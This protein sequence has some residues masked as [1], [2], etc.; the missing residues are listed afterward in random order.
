MIERI[1]TPVRR[2]LGPFANP[3]LRAAQSLRR[4]LA[5]AWLLVVWGGERRRRAL[6]WLL[7]RHYRALFLRQW[8]WADEEP[9]FF[10]HRI[11]SFEFAI[12]DHHGFTHYRG[13]FAA[14][15]VREGDRVLD[16]GCGDGFFTRRFLAPV[17]ARVDG[18]DIEP[19]AIEH[20]KAHNAAS[21]V[22]YFTSDAVA[23][24]FPAAEYDL[25]VWD[26]ALGHFPP[27]TT[28]RMLAKIRAALSD[29]GA[30]VGSESLGRVEGQ[31]DHLQ[32]F[33]GVEDLD[34]L[35]S[36]HFPHVEVRALRYRLPGGAVRTEAFWRCAGSPA[37][38]D[39]ARWRSHAPAAR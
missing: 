9:H 22:G 24:D 21:N 33:D 39:E 8:R 32:F 17:A 38:L 29:G 6:E 14:E 36:E 35:F 27:D 25:I 37:R 12:G 30:F 11:D 34:A 16:I 28:Q 3:A 7:R 10:D 23:D 19:S 31:G 5:R 2:V 4:R 1:P 18:V 20:A 26:G 15:L 13:Y